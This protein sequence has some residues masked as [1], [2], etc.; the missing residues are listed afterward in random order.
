MTK[1]NKVPLD[2]AEEDT[3][4]TKYSGLTKNEI[5]TAASAIR[6]QQSK[7]SELSGTL[8]GVLGVFEK[9]GGHKAALK[10]ASRVTSMEPAECA[11]FMR[12]FMAYFDALGGNDQVDMFDQASEADMNKENIA[13]VSKPAEPEMGQEAVN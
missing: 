9:Q 1:A 10:A 6:T 3:E 2:L 12:S 11:D 4:R 13:I 5:E 8:S 7:S